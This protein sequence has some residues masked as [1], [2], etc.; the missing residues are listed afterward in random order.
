MG[1]IV[2]TRGIRGIFTLGA[3]ATVMAGAALTFGACATDSHTEMNGK[4]EAPAPK[5]A[6]MVEGKLEPFECGEITS[7]YTMN[8]VFLASQPAEE[9]FRH[10][11]E[12]GIKT[13]V[14]LRKAG[15]LK[16][17]D[18][19]AL[20]AELGFEY[21]HHGYRAPDELT[22]ELFDTVRGY[23]ND[24]SKIPMLIH[25]SSGN[26]VG[27]LWAAHRVLDHKIDLED[28]VKEA[29]TIGM[30]LPGYETRLREYVAAKQA[31]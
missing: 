21:H 14:N 11:K 17:F 31:K 23:L 28:A 24:Q 27:A 18:Q 6:P 4:N 1:Q 5:T 19:D 9:D 13:I 29:K 20:M 7:L 2:K 16:E 22:D 10:A 3:L 26:R 30:K 12:A 25:C 8:G 15:E